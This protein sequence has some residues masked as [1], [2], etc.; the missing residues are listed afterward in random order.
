MPFVLFPLEATQTP[1]ATD[2]YVLT[3][4]FVLTGLVTFIAWFRP[5]FF[6]RTLA[7]VA[8]LFRHWDPTSEKWYRSEI[9]FWLLRLT[10]TLMFLVCT[11]ALAKLLLSGS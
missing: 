6:R 4:A 9:N 7:L 3:I 10:M 8:L 11:L 2:I 5:A 1:H